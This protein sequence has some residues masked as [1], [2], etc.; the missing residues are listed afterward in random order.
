MIQD[1]ARRMKERGIQAELE[2]FDSGMINYANYLA[3]RELI[4]APFYF[5]LLLGNIACAQANLLHVGVMVNDLPAD[6]CWSLAGIGDMQLSMNS[7]AIAMGGGVRVG[8]E[9]NLY[10]D[11]ERTKL[12]RNEDLL[13]RVHTIAEANERPLM[14]AGELRTK[15]G[16]NPDNGTY[17]TAA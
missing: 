5:N 3:K 1:L 10:F 17:G 9:D 16:L 14:S 4:S 7:L 15:L 6:S 12:A 2:A 13:R 11:R 8:L